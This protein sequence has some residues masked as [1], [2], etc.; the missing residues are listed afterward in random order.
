MESEKER[1]VDIKGYES[2]YQVSNLGN[3]KRLDFIFPNGRL[4]RGRQLKVGLHSA[5]YNNVGLCI[6]GRVKSRFVHRLVAEGFIGDLTE[7]EVDHIDGNK[8]NNKLENLRICTRRQNITFFRLRTNP[9]KGVGYRKDGLRNKWKAYITF[10]K[11]EVH[12]GYFDTEQEASDAYQSKLKSL[13]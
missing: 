3:I 2:I 7:K 5:G 11:K 9:N 10:D 12:L 1:W 13:G 8:L 4:W 6:N